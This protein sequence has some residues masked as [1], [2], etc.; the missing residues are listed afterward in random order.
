M[1]WTMLAKDDCG[2]A[3]WLNYSFGGYPEDF[4]CPAIRICAISL[5]RQKVS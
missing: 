1:T 4:D 5:L 2:N 3:R